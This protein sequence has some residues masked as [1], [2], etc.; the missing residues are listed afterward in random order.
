MCVC[1]CVFYDDGDVHDDVSV[2]KHFI[3]PYRHTVS[4]CYGNI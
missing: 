4:V 1:V 2:T 3:R